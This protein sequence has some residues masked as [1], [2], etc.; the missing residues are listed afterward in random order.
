LATTEVQLEATSD[1]VQAKAAI[2][3]KL[4]AIDQRTGDNMSSSATGWEA[5]RAPLELIDQSQ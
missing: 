4:K 5:S 1:D 3:Q 2:I